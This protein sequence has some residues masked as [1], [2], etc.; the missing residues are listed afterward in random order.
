MLEVVHLTKEYVGVV[1]EEI[2]ADMGFQVQ[3]QV[4]EVHFKEGES[5]RKGHI[6]ASIDPV[7]LQSAYDAS[8][9][10]LL[11]AE[12]AYARM[13]KLYDN[14]SLPEIKFVEVRTKLQQARSAEQV[15]SRNLRDRHIR[16][17]FSG[18]VGYRS[19]EVGE[20][21]VPGKPVFKLLKTDGVKVSVSLPEKDI[22]TIGRD[23]DA[24]ICVSALGDRIYTGKVTERNILNSKISH[25]YQVKIGLRTVDEVL[26]PGMVC[27][28]W[29]NDGNGD[30]SVVIIPNRTVH[31]PFVIAI[32]KLFD[33]CPK[34][35]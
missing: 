28:V 4:S 3:G 5:V 14:Q 25:A 17:P 26:V 13:K 34:A 1:E 33:R 12:D 18:V 30:M 15:A 8:K 29:L 21:A 35:M 10:T 20:T 6:L 22:V 19:L 7:S 16:A 31:P 24:R 23:A 2:S 11:Q 32:N 9:A 27:R